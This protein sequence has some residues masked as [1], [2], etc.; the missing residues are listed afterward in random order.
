MLERNKI[1]NNLHGRLVRDYELRDKGQPRTHGLIDTWW[2]RQDCSSIQLTERLLSKKERRWHE[3]AVEVWST[4]RP[5]STQCPPA[6]FNF[7]F[8]TA[9]ELAA[10]DKEP[11]GNMLIYTMG[12]EADDILRSFKL[13]EIDTKNTA[14]WKKIL[15][16]ILSKREMWYMRELDLTAVSRKENLWT[17]S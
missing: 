5:S 12:D 7:R 14:W 16:I 9:A 10:K 11:Q 6:S 13:S 4:W 17:H 8:R 2:Q 3:K 1:L 15:K